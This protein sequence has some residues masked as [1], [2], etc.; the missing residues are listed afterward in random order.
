VLSTSGLGSDR[1]MVVLFFFEH[2]KAPLLSG[3]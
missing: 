1:N 3:A 2:E